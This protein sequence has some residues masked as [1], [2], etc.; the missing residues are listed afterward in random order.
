MKSSFFLAL[1]FAVLFINAQTTYNYWVNSIGGS[2]GDAVYDIETDNDDNVLVTGKF[3][4]TVDFDPDSGVFNLIANGTGDEIFVAKYDSNGSFIWAKSFGGIYYD[5]GYDLIVNDSNDVFIVGTFML[6]V[7]FDPGVGV[8]N[9]TSSGNVDIFILK[10]NENGDFVFVKQVGGNGID[11]GSKMILDQN[12]N[13]LITGYFA[14]I[15]DFDPGP[16]VF[17]LVPDG[18]DA[19][20]LKLDSFGNFVWVKHFTGPDTDKG[21]DIAVDTQSYIYFGGEFADSIDLDPGAGTMIAVGTNPAACTFIEKLNENG[22][23]I[24]AKSFLSDGWV[25][26][27]GIAL[28]ANGNLIL[29]GQFTDTVDFDPGIMEYSLGGLDYTFICNLDGNGNFNWVKSF[30][31][32]M[33][34]STDI[35]VD[36]ND[37]IY[38]SGSFM[39]LIDFCP[40]STMCYYDA[41]GN[42]SSYLAMLNSAGS[43]QNAVTFNS[44]DNNVGFGV[45]VD[46]DLNIYVCGRFNESVDFD[47][48]D[49]VNNVLSN[50]SSDGYIIKFKAC[51]NSVISYSTDYCGSF[52]SPSGNYT[53]TTNGLYYDTIATSNGCPTVYMINLN[54]TTLD[55][56][57]INYGGTLSAVESSAT[58]Q[59]M[60]CDSLIISGETFQSFTPVTNGD[61]AV[62]VSKY[63]CTDTS[64]C[65]SV[66]NAGADE[67]FPEKKFNVFPNPAFGNISV[68]VS[69]TNDDVF[70]LIR[71]ASGDLVER[72]DINSNAQNVI[73][74]DWS[75]GVYFIEFFEGDNLVEIKTQIIN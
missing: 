47:P 61:Y 16:G 8:A 26:L 1:F 21:I 66:T 18:P 64:V 23:M 59:W 6:T 72:Y 74:A 5:T 4:G 65:I 36:Q 35:D 58:Y 14:Y 51:N 43:F 55:A 70:V 67:I 37:N 60:Y 24:W 10:L 44:P 29:S 48:G 63:N 46:D 71:D 56:S 38:L 34:Y 73:E 69:G 11:V 13:I 54:F 15:A 2:G 25:Y 9:L 57:I 20:L 28:Q 22:D 50:G 19:F 75:S 31:Q 12:G 41:G 40:D 39:G 45:N 27:Y 30:T 3:Q 33:N 7:D 52:L 68:S 32:T 49:G 42:F 17:S 62:I 53:W